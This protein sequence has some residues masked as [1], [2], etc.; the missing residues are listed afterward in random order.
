MTRLARGLIA[1]LV[2]GLLFASLPGV[3]FA[4]KKGVTTGETVVRNGPSR[5][6]KVLGKLPAGKN[7]LVGKVEGDWLLVRFQVK[8]NG[9][10][11]TVTGWVSKVNVRPVSSSTAPPKKP[12][13]TEETTPPPKK[14]ASSGPPEAVIAPPPYD[15]PLH[16]GLDAEVGPAALVNSYTLTSGSFT[17]ETGFVPYVGAHGSVSYYLLRYVGVQVAVSGGSGT[18]NGQ[19]GGTRVEGLP[20]QII[21]GSAAV[22]GRYGFGPA[23]VYGAAGY[24]LIQYQITPVQNGAGQSVF[25]SSSQYSGVTAG[26]GVGL[27]LMDGALRASL[28]GQY[29]L[30]PSFSEDANTGAVDALTGI[31]AQL[32][33]RYAVTEKIGAGLVLSGTQLTTDFSGTGQR[34][35]RSVADA[36]VSDL[37]ATAGLTATYV[38]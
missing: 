2:T 14:T 26:A 11:A 19:I 33:V 38:F 23:F 1:A 27:E 7:L 3:A 17:Q 32:A 35:G 4:A 10:P 30:A 20:T 22:V 12:P 6:A 36:S 28:G 16:T 25:L 8:K 9:Q 31:S 5:E 29:W 18:I 13:A 21:D 34:F 37:F 15:G 24:R